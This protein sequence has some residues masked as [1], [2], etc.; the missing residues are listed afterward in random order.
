MCLRRCGAQRAH[1]RSRVRIAGRLTG[2]DQDQKICWLWGQVLIA[3]SLWERV[4][5]RALAV[6]QASQPPRLSQE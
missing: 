3:L 4:G 1:Q 5:V 2:N 6:P